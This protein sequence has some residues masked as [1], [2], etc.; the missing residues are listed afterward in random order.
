MCNFQSQKL[1]EL[2][3]IQAM[4]RLFTLYQYENEFKVRIDNTVEV[5]Y[6]YWGSVGEYETM[7]DAQIKK[8]GE[9][10][11]SL[12]ADKVKL[13]QYRNKCKD[14]ICGYFNGLFGSQF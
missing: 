7:I 2:S 8:D 1:P 14:K 5:L 9:D 3:L 6:H 11:T 4:Q 10:V 13:K 12:W